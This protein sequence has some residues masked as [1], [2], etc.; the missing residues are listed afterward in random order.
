MAHHLFNIVASWIARTRFGK[1]HPQT[2]EALLQD[3]E[4]FTG[5]VEGAMLFEHI[6]ETQ[7]LGALIALPGK[8]MRYALNDAKNDGVEEALRQITHAFAFSVAVDATTYQGDFEMCD[9]ERAAEDGEFVYEG[10]PDEDISLISA[11]TKTMARMIQMAGETHP[12][13]VYDDLGSTILRDHGALDARCFALAAQ[14]GLPASLWALSTASL[15]LAVDMGSMPVDVASRRLFGS[16]THSITD[17]LPDRD[18]SHAHVD[19]RKNLPNLTAVTGITESEA[20]A[21]YGSL[22]DEWWEERP[23]LDFWLELLDGISEG[24]HLSSE[25]PQVDLEL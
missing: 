25:G 21:T 23:L 19:W 18:W 16:D 13:L 6:L 14:D 4:D 10:D 11:P 1:P 5:D 17:L 2:D 8:T 9:I 7:K 12:D 15:L 22:M 3:A 20:E 24:L